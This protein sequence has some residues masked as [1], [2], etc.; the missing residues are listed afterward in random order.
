MSNVKIQDVEDIANAKY[1]MLSLLRE[2]DNMRAKDKD[3][4]NYKKQIEQLEYDLK[5][6]DDKTLLNK[7]NQVYVPYLQ[8]LLE[9]NY[10]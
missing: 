10:D 2:L 3:N 6:Y 4:P 8:S 5:H 9:K 7:V 1:V